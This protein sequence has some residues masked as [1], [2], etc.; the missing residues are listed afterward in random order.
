MAINDPWF[1]RCMRLMVFSRGF[2]RRSGPH[3]GRLKGVV[4]VWRV[5]PLI[6]GGDGT[7]GADHP[8]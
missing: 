4:L 6:Y 3:V 7:M 1:S 2:Q 8:V 5:R